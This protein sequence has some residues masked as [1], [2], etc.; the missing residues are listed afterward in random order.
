VRPRHGFVPGAVPGGWCCRRPTRARRRCW[1]WPSIQAA[2][3]DDP[4]RLRCARC[5]QPGRAADARGGE[6][7]AAWQECARRLADDLD[8]TLVDDRGT[9]IT[10]HAFATIGQELGRL[11]RPW[12]SDL[13][14]G[15]A[16][17]RR[18]FS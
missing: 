17:A 14:A 15:T 1:C 8:A 4:A 18:L 6:P 12:S 16:A 13:A 3:S 9:V 5:P 2:L 11:Y 10:L 7:F